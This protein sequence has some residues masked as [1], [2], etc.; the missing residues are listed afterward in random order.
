MVKSIWRKFDFW[1]FGTVVILSLFGIVMIQSAIAGNIELSGYVNRQVTFVSIGMAVI[2]LFA[3]INYQYWASITKLMYIFAVGFLVVIF[4]VGE[5]RFGSARWFETGLF[6]IQPSELAK[7]ILVLVMADYF[8]K[9]WEQPKDFGWV[10]KSFVLM[11]GVVVWIILQPNL[12]T[13]IVIM[14]LWFAFLWISGLPPKYLIW[15][16][17]IGIVVGL[18]FFQFVMEDYQ[19]TRITQFLVPD[20]TA[21]HGNTYNVDQALISIGSGGLFGQGYGQGS[22]V[23]LRFL[24]VRHTDFIFSAMAEEFGFVGTTVVI[25]LLLF[26]IV[27]C[28]VIAQQA[29]DQFG[30]LIA[31]GFGVLMVFQMAVNI[32]VNMNVIPVTGLTLPFIS[33]GGS[34]ILSLSLGIGLVESVAVR[35]ST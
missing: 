6:S 23:Q 13:S 9:S 5:A 26:V 27:R 20:P 24:K 1:L 25:L 21:R 33:Y 29:S 10:L 14:V 3:L 32:G 11:M 19:K 34:S 35:R 8:A 17:V 7:I 2:I 16:A 28:F 18:L 30:A 12:S 15:F 31:F 4:V 22:Q